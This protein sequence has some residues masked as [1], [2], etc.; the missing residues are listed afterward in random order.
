[1]ILVRH[2]ESRFNEAFHRDRV[3][4]GIPDA[5]LTEL[6]TR[7]ALGTAAGLAERDLRHIVSSPYTRALQ[8]ASIIAEVLGLS[9]EV[10][11]LVG[12]RA[13]MS[14]DIGTPVTGLAA[15]WPQLDF[16]RLPE[17]WWPEPDEP[18]ANLHRR[19]AEFRARM[20]AV[21]DRDRLLV[22]SHWGFIRALTGHEVHNCGVVHYPLTAPEPIRAHRPWR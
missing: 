16:T 12:E 18:E 8:T 13:A 22:V 17:R 11:P 1:M 9:I 20:A 15:D 21:P 7:Q 19:A 2:G 14:C 3:D 10:D 5:P 4:P 6:G